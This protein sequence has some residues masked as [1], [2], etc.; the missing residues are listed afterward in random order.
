MKQRPYGIPPKRTYESYIEDPVFYLSP[1]NYKVNASVGTSRR[2]LKCFL[3]IFDTGAGP[4]IVRKDILSADD[5][6]NLDKSRHIANLSSASKHPLD[7][8]GIIY[9]YVDINGYCVRQPFVIASELSCDVLLG[10]TYIDQ[11]VAHLYVRKRTVVLADGTAARLHLRQSRSL[12]RDHEEPIQVPDTE[13]PPKL[14][15]MAR[16]AVLEPQS[17]TVISVLV[18]SDPS[19]SESNVFNIPDNLDFKIPVPDWD[20]IR[21]NNIDNVDMPSDKNNQNNSEAQ[22]TSENL[23]RPSSYPLIPKEV[24]EKISTAPGQEG[25]ISTEEKIFSVDDVDLSHL[26]DAQQ[27]K[28]RSMLRPLSD[29]WS[30]TLGEV[31]A[32]QHRIDI[33]PTARPFRSQPYRAGLKDREVQRYEV[34]RQLK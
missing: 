8:L 2:S 16:R 23:V 33:D 31:N 9:L 11:H 3:S 15:T 22:T 28:V 24:L 29:M 14:V 5:L 26:S 19:L 20:E 13:S 12:E 30:G 27:K 32:G 10:T 34:Q 7:V 25:K 18:K 17:E 1:Y 21:I 4:N 6:S